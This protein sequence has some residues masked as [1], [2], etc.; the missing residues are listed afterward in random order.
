[1]LKM[2]TLAKAKDIVPRSLTMRSKLWLLAGFLIAIMVGSNSFMR[3]QVIESS[4]ALGGQ[5]EL[6]QRVAAANAALRSFGELKYWLADLE[7]SWLTESEENAEEA[8][9]A[10]DEQLQAIRA[11]APDQVAEVPD[12]VDKLFEIL[13]RAVDAYVDENRVQGNSLVAD[14]RASVQAVDEILV[15]IVDDL[16]QQA[17]ATG[18]AAI[19]AADDTARYSLIILVAA[20]LAGLFLTWSILRSVLGP[21]NQMVGAM[22]ALAENDN[23]IEIPAIGRKDEIGNMAQAVQVFKDNAIERGR[24]E[25]EQERVAAEAKARA[26]HIAEICAEFDRAVSVALKTVNSAAQDMESSAQS[27]SATAEQTSTQAT[28]AASASGEVNSNVQTVATAAEELSSSVAEIGRQVAQSSDISNRAVSEAERTDGT[29]QG[30]AE[31]AQRIGKVV[32]LINDIAA[33]TNLLALNATIEAARA[34]EAGK[35]F[36]VVASEVKNLAN[37]TAK[38]TDEIANQISGMRQVTGEVVQAIEGI[39]KTIGEVNEIA[40]GIAAAVE[41]QSAATDEIARN[42]QKAAQGTQEVSANIGGVT[43]AA[44]ETGQASIQVLDAARE[45]NGQAATL[46]EEIDKFLVN[47]K[48][49]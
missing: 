4:A 14:A 44:G 29:V 27:M 3:V 49:V 38:A 6:Q 43:A 42:V 22:K 30:L 36:A 11:F 20:A 1:M 21:F 41:E 23:T 18:E 17:S 48:A 33:Q 2:I 16:K 24:L 35:G 5:A 15:K 39:G 28:A 9:A 10:L 34:G 25:A 40:M 12:H 32:N 45:V 47:V 46:R 13:L 7:V 26:E 37:Q 31:V 19:A 8:R